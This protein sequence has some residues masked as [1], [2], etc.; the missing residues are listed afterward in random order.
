MQTVEA[1]CIIL[2]ESSLSPYQKVPISEC[3][4]DIEGLIRDLWEYSYSTKQ[5]DP[6][7]V[8]VDNMVF[9]AISSLYDNG[10]Y[11]VAEDGVIWNRFD[12]D[13]EIKEVPLCGKLTEDL[14]NDRPYHVTI[15]RAPPEQ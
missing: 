12:V 14:Y 3:Q 11:V 15:T 2:D 5:P 13:Y 6:T 1:N 10:Y 8:E 4:E 7:A 9:E